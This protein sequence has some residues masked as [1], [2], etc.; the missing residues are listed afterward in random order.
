M[1]RVFEYAYRMSE[2]EKLSSTATA[3]LPDVTS[4]ATAPDS[5]YDRQDPLQVMDRCTK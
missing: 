4:S 2:S 3:L 1:S 5:G